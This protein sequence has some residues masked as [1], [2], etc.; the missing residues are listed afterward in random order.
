MGIPTS[1]LGKNCEAR[2]LVEITWKY[3]LHEGSCAVDSH[4]ASRM[5]PEDIPNWINIFVQS[6][7]PSHTTPIQ[8]LQPRMPRRGNVDAVSG[9]HGKNTT[10]VSMF[11]AMAHARRHAYTYTPVHG[12]QRHTSI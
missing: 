5:T 4:L 9:I 3:H 10:E 8:R 1:L 6:L 12:V 11:L 7:V 2:P